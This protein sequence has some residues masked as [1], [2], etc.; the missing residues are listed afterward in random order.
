MPEHYFV[1]EIMLY[2]RKKAPKNLKITVCSFNIWF[3]VC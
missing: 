2:L 3:K 1:R